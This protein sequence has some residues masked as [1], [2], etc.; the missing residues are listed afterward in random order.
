MGKD[1][2]SGG[3][4]GRCYFRPRRTFGR[5]HSHP[6]ALG[7]MKSCGVAVVVFLGVLVGVATLGNNALAQGRPPSATAES[8][9]RIRELLDLLADPSVREWLDQRRSAETVAR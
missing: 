3:D 9:P 4:A 7:S 8:P 6:D 2:G 1:L 5:L